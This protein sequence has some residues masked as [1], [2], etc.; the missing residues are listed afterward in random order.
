MYKQAAL[1][2]GD[3]SFV[4]QV[5]M[6]LHFRNYSQNMNIKVTTTYIEFSKQFILAE[7]VREQ[8]PLWK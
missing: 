2:H 7:T 3:K 8:K 5:K 6:I 1:A 4:M